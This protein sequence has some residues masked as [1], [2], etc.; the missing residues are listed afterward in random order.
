[1]AVISTANN[2]KALWPGIHAWFGRFYNEH[3]PEWPELFESQS[4]EKA[5]EELAEISGFGLA[6]IKSQGAAISY[7]SESQQ[8]TPRLTHVAYALGYIV[9]HEEMMDNLYEKV[10]RRRT[11]ALAFSMRTTKEIVH[12]NVYNRAF[13]SSYTVTGGDGVELLSTSHP[14]LNGNQSNELATAAD[15][16]ETSLEDLCIQIYGAKNG[17]GHQIALRPQKLIVHRNDWFEANRI[18]KS[19]LQNDSAQNAINAL[20]VTNA[21]PGG[22]AMN[23]Y[24]DDTDAW[25]VRTDC[26]DSMISFQREALSFDEDNDGDTKNQ[27]Y[28]AYE[29]YEP[30]WA[31]FRGLFG[32]PG[33]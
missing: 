13:N 1:M 18:L 6:P 15:L 32:S 9:T 5:Y 29:R 31:D 7:D 22:V 8:I 30:K 19:V 20:R 12:A 16:S 23:H 4:S 33:A 25:F 28:T 11:R 17:R 24:L 10:A 14:T 2:P 3:P 26:P 21:I 27:K